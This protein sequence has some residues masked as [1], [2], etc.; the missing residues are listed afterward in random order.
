MRGWALSLEAGFLGMGSLPL[1]ISRSLHSFDSARLG[2]KLSVI[3]QLVESF[4]HFQADRLFQFQGQ[5]M[6]Y[7]AILLNF[8]GLLVNAWLGIKSGSRFLGHGK[9]SSS[10]ISKF[11]LFRF[12]PTWMQT[13]CDRCRLWGQSNVTLCYCGLLK[14]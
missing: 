9:S 5:R 8:T 3:G 4:R 14:Y 11:T 12:C 2:C 13:V 1:L 6:G 7:G 10:Y